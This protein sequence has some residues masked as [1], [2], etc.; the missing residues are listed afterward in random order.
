MCSDVMVYPY[1]IYQARLAGA[2]AIKLVSP[3]LPEKVTLVLSLPKS[4]A[5]VKAS[6]LRDLLYNE[7]VTTSMQTCRHGKRIPPDTERSKYISMLSG[8]ARRR[9]ESYGPSIRYSYS[10]NILCNSPRGHD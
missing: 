6:C 2:D 3:A 1:Q 4:I 7:G 10:H 5:I 9:N 8:E